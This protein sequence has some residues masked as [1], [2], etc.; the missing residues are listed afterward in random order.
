MKNQ[1]LQNFFKTLF[2]M[3]NY[4]F[5]PTVLFFWYYI[6][7]LV[8]FLIK[9]DPVLKVDMVLMMILNSII[10]TVVSI[11]DFVTTY[12]GAFILPIERLIPRFYEKTGLSNG[13]S[14]F[15]CP[16]FNIKG[17]AFELGYYLLLIFLINL[18]VVK[19]SKKRPTK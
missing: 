15:Y 3:R 10:T 7:F 8:S 5:L 18:L 16:G 13:C 14:L 12:F 9:D 2:F 1:K 11:G 6:V 4:G 19:L 17:Y